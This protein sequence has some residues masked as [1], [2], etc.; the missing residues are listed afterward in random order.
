MGI[1]DHKIVNLGHTVFQDGGL[2]VAGVSSS[3]LDLPFV[4]F[5]SLQL[6][7]AFFRSHF[8]AKSLYRDIIVIVG[9]VS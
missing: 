2:S 5:V 4:T 9:A 3:Q 8:S 1:G 6:I 7:F